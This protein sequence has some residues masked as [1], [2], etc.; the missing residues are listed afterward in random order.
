MCYVFL[1]EGVTTTTLT[2]PR[3]SDKILVLRRR[4][5]FLYCNE[6][7][8][9]RRY[10]VRFSITQGSFYKRRERNFFTKP[11]APVLFSLN[12]V[13]W[14]PTSHWYVVRTKIT[15]VKENGQKGRSWS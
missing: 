6:S 10:G 15:R 3:S 1:Q 4:R 2:T 13:E 5:I 11:P 7:R 8:R 9:L 14:V 12:M